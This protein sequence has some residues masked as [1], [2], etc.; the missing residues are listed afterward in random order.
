MIEVNHFSYPVYR[1]FLQYL[2]TDKVSLP[3]EEAIGMYKN[4]LKML[5]SSCTCIINT[6]VILLT[7]NKFKLCFCR[8]VR[9]SQF[10]L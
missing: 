5:L 3:P 7:Y 6:T 8:F 4:D 2:Y 10:L 9:F 1:A